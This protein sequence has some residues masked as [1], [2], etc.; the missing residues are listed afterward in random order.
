M[1]NA[2]GLLQ[3]TPEPKTLAQKVWPRMKKLVAAAKVTF[4]VST[5]A[6]ASVGGAL[7][8]IVAVAAGVDLVIFAVDCHLKVNARMVEGEDGTKMTRMAAMKDYL[9][10]KEFAKDLGSLMLA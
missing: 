10:S 9:K 2:L 3:K 1:D 8:I 4:Y 5:V 7:P 6:G